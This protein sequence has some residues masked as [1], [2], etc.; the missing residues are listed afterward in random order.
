M[1]DREEII[2]KL[3]EILQG[4]LTSFFEESKIESMTKETRMQTDLGLDSLDGYEF[5][6][7]I[8]GKMGISIPDDLPLFVCQVA[9]LAT[10]RYEQCILNS[11]A[12]FMTGEEWDD[13]LPT[14]ATDGVWRR[15]EPGPRLGRRG[16]RR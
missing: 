9:R 11:R 7:Q 10:G 3:K 2:S 14:W 12:A 13:V 1:P 15:M 4:D 8:E 5:I 6:Y 16:S